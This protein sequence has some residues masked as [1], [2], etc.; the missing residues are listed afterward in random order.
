MNEKKD[1]V[2][3]KDFEMC[4]WG[5]LI[6]EDECVMTPAKKD[7]NLVVR[8]AMRKETARDM[9]DS[10]RYA[11]KIRKCAIQRGDWDEEDRK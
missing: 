3:F 1:T 5:H 4:P 6:K 11:N 7:Y 10:Y 2:F 8:A 9:D